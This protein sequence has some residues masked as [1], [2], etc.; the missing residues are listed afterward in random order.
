M[1]K[2]GII[3]LCICYLIPLLCISVPVVSAEDLQNEKKEFGC[4]SLD[5]ESTRLGNGQLVDNVQSAIVYETNSD[6]L[7][8]SF[9][10]DQQMDP[11]TFVKIMTGYIAAEKGN[12]EDKITV[13]ASAMNSI[14]SAAVTIGLKVGEILTLEDLMHCLLV[15]S[16]N[17]AAVIIA[18]YISGNQAAF[19]AEMN[20]VAEELG[21]T[22][23]HF[24]NATG[25]Y[26][27]NQ[28][29]TARDIA[30]ILERAL[31]NEAFRRA[32]CAADY[33]VPATNL[34]DERLLVTTNYLIYGNL[35]GVLYYV[36]R[37]VTG[38]RVGV[39][40]TGKRMVAAVSEYET[41]EMI[42]IVMGSDSEW[43]EDK[44][45]ISI[46]GGY[47]ETSA[48]LN[49]AYAAPKVSQVLFENQA[50]MQLPVQN[51]DSDVVIGPKESVY[52][53]IQSDETLSGISYR[54]SHTGQEFE[55]PIHKGDYVSTVEVWSDGI[56]VAMT[57]LYAMNSVS[58]IEASTEP[59]VD[60]ETKNGTN[61]T[62]FMFIIAVVVLIAAVYF[63]RQ[64]QI[65]KA[66]RRSQHNRRNRRRSK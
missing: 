51:G 56:C 14:S 8:Y 47:L 53:L 2:I 29:S 5:A 65:A 58:R 61:G 27:E 64:M 39:S 40:N 43:S 66:R 16:S 50:M 18:E 55:A 9:N 26:D 52:A 31:E 45:Y 37:R 54:F 42:S 25:L 1:K 48:L 21:C 4:Y 22:N 10:A 57:D 32:F 34:S 12:M 28:L 30:K 13:T 23:T 33:T 60:T 44:T 62:I 17:E 38:G 7:M 59:V 24:T 41:M 63:V 49:A 46:F 36:D 20:R 19:V 3:C 15:R 11:A 35:D 6:T